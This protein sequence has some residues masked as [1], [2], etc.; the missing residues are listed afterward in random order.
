MYQTFLK[1]SDIKFWLKMSYFDLWLQ[2]WYG[3]FVMYWTPKNNSFSTNS[4]NTSYSF[5][6]E[7]VNT[8]IWCSK[9]RFSL[10]HPNKLI[11]KRENESSILLQCIFMKN[12]WTAGSTLKTM[13]KLSM[14]NCSFQKWIE[15]HFLDLHLKIRQ[16]PI[17]ILSTHPVIPC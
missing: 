16:S 5:W 3:S 4:S 7:F 10:W 6:F 12:S 1:G 13:K 8:N 11:R 17:A 2:I 9:T 14:E 15:G